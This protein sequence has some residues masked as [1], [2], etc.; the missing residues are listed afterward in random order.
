MRRRITT[1]LQAAGLSDGEVTVYLLLLKLQKAGVAEIVTLSGMNTMTAYR[2]VKRLLGRELIS[3]VTLNRKQS[4][5]IPLSLRSLV[6]RLESDERKMRKLQLAL[7]GV[8]KLLP[9]LDSDQRVSDAEPV[10]IKEGLEAFREEYLKLPDYCSEEYLH[11]GS[12]QN[13]WRIAGMSDESPEEMGFRHKRFKRHIFARV[14]N[15]WAPE[16]DAIMQRDSRE[17]R[18]MRISDALPITRDYMGFADDHISHFICDAKNPKVIVIR[19]PELVGFHRKQ[20]K[21]LWEGSAGAG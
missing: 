5:Y 19:H 15:T 7:R 21:Q 2:T 6:Q 13:Y 18:T 4:V 10:E 3:E 11:I 1:L 16:M 9:F 12:M 8:D 17:L 14:F 20:F